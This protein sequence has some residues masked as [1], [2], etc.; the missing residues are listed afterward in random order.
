[1]GACQEFRKRFVGGE[2]QHAFS[3]CIITGNTGWLIRKET[4]Y[5]YYTEVRTGCY[6]AAGT[7]IKISYSMST[8]QK[9]QENS[10]R[11]TAEWV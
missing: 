7:T 1:M 8:G 4:G 10:F 5:G 2:N 9:M 6:S 3:Y 11:E